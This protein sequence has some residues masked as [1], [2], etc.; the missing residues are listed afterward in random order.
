MS[1]LI[2]LE[3]LHNDIIRWSYYPACC[4][5]LGSCLHIVAFWEEVERKLTVKFFLHAT[6]N[7]AAKFSYDQVCLL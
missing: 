2:S 3:A 4:L 1:Y 6:G 7:I 5:T